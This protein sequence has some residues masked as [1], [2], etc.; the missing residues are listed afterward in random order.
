MWWLE[1]ELEKVHDEIERMEWQLEVARKD[2]ELCVARA[3]EGGRVDHKKELETQDE[4]VALLKEKAQQLTKVQ[5]SSKPAPVVSVSGS[6]SETPVVSVVTAPATK[7]RERDL[8]GE[9]RSN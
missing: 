8:K 3:R 2:T 4:L 9:G 7:V 5:T 6:E 1:E